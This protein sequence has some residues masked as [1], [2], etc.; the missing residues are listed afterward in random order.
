MQLR[1]KTTV[2]NEGAV[3]FELCMLLLL[4]MSWGQS[5][6]K[7]TSVGWGSLQLE[8]KCALHYDMSLI[9]SSK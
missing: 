7:N 3:S 6:L 8:G 4:D 9:A 5:L 2:L 1:Y